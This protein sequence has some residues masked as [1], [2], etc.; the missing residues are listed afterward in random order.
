MNH[1][2]EY[3]GGI[4]HGGIVQLCANQCFSEVSSPVVSNDDSIEA[5]IGGEILMNQLSDTLSLYTSWG[6]ISSADIG[7]GKWGH[8]QCQDGL[9]V[10]KSRRC[11]H[12]DWVNVGSGMATGNEVMMK[13][14]R[15]GDVI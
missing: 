13:S 11:C 8:W 14:F 1:R 5:G 2:W 15:S 4:E 7:F 6:G 3:C 10:V 12:E 9:W